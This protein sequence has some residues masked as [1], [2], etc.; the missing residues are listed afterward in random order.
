[1]IEAYYKSACSTIL[2]FKANMTISIS[3]SKNKFS[4]KSQT[5]K[6]V[7]Q[8]TKKRY[9]KKK[10]RLHFIKKRKISKVRISKSIGIIKMDSSLKSKV[11][12]AQYKHLVL[13]NL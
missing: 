2:K 3:R 5:I 4:L 1:M 6:K 7:M 10:S 11:L 8:A 13:N 12:L 9:F